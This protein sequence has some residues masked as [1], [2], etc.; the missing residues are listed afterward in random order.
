MLAGDFFYG[1]DIRGRVV[2]NAARG[3]RAHP[4]LGLLVLASVLVAAGATAVAFLIAAILTVALLLVGLIVVSA[5]VALLRPALLELTDYDAPSSAAAGSASLKAY[6]ASVDE[7]SQ[8]AELAIAAGSFKPWA[9]GAARSAANNATRLHDRAAGLAR[10][11][12][13]SPR[14]G[15]LTRELEQ[16]VGL[17]RRYISEIRQRPPE[18]LPSEVIGW[19]REELNHRRDTLLAHLRETDFRAASV[20]R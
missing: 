8:L 15:P 13:R 6:L 5:V 11:W 18:R 1:R 17:L 16:A 20:E 19:Y 14:F 10:H 7:F 12:R 4:V 2:R 9:G 3:F